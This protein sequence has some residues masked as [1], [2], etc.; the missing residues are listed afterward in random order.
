MSLNVVPENTHV[1]YPFLY[2]DL[3]V[4]YAPSDV[5]VPKYPFREN[6]PDRNEGHG[7][8]LYILLK[9]CAYALFRL[10]VLVL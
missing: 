2:D 4:Y 10:V 8:L 1:R 3:F 6:L 5:A 7:L 9:I